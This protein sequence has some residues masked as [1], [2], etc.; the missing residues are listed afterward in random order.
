MRTYGTLTHIPDGPT[1]AVWVIEAEPQVAMRL[2]RIFP[3]IATHRAK[4]LTLRDTPEIANE[5]DWVMERWPLEVDAAAKKRLRRQTLLYEEDR[6]AVEQIL[7]GKSVHEGS[8]WHEPS[9]AREKRPEQYQAADL[10]LQT[11]GLLLGDPLGKGKSYSSLLV[12]RDPAALPAL[13]VT[14]THLPAQWER[15]AN[16]AFPFLRTHRL[17]TGTPYDIA[18]RRELK[19]HEPDILISNY[20]KLTGWADHLAGRVKT[21]IF[22][23]CEELRR[24]ESEKYKAAARIADEADYRMGLSGEP[25]Y[26]YGEE[27][28]NILDVIQPG[29]LGG[30][31]EFRREWGKDFG[32]D[33]WGV[34][35]PE[36]FGLHLREL[37]LFLRRPWESDE[38]APHLYHHAI[39]TDEDV[40]DAESAEIERLAQVILSSTDRKEVFKASG[41][42]DWTIRRAT[43]LAKAP[44]VADFTRMILETGKPAVLWGWHHDVYDVWMDRLKD[45]E[46]VLYTGQESAAQKK[47]AEQAFLD[48]DTPLLIMSLRSGA[49]LDGLQKVCRVGIFG[50]LD[51]APAMHKECMGRLDPRRTPAKQRPKDP[52]PALGYFLVSTAGSDPHMAQVLDVKR[53]QADPI[54]DPGMAALTKAPDN[55]GHIRELAEEALRRRGAQGVAA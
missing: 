42:I 50:E 35:D 40:Y 45:F 47:N 49:G 46:P 7:S 51:W 10:V 53:M 6:E 2:K 33:K 19:G 21:V 36:A 24:P 12:L 39:D 15:E 28:Y 34:R 1:G 48:G 30:R 5:L 8:G 3:R 20:A 32:N 11:G 52:E 14:L 18:S 41:Q 22:D 37:G 13:V 25:V 16:D 17:R 23:Q 44:F 54:K 4:K 9:P 38:L 29:A 26:N 27:A 43:G 31:D 55:A